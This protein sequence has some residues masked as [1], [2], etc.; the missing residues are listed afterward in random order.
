MTDRKSRLLELDKRGK[1][2]FA[3]KRA[4]ETNIAATFARIRREMKEAEKLPPA[5]VKQIQRKVA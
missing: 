2:T 4:A 5:N 3:Y 1:P